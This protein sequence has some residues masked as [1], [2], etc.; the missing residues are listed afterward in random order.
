MPYVVV[1][2]NVAASGVSATPAMAAISRALA[3]ALSKPE[4]VVMVQLCLDTP[5][6]FAASDAPCAMIQLRSIG[7]VDLEHNPTT[8]AALTDVVSQVLSVPADRI[9]MNLDDIERTNWARS[10]NLVLAPASLPAPTV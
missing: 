9:F 8:V 6:L 2:S 5:M 4:T 3:A 1:T 7:K 10:G